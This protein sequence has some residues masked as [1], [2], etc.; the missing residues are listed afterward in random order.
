MED[1]VD[2]AFPY[3]VRI[4]IYH[5]D[6]RDVICGGSLI[7]EE[8]VLTAASCVLN[9]DKKYIF[10][11]VGQNHIDSEMNA[12]LSSGVD[13]IYV[14]SDIA[15]LHLIK[16]ATGVPYVSIPDPRIDRNMDNVINEDDYLE[17]VNSGE[18]GVIVGFKMITLNNKPWYTTYWHPYL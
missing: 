3:Y 1:V 15:L 5:E 11:V 2:N 17:N 6:R 8:Y 18:S 9:Q 12:L 16:P 7:S 4:S 14:S 10:V 13:S